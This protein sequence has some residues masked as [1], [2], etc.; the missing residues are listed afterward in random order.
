MTKRKD[1]IIVN[2]QRNTSQMQTSSKNEENNEK[3]MQTADTV[4]QRTRGDLF[5]QVT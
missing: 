1:K 5:M 2:L 4:Q 3:C